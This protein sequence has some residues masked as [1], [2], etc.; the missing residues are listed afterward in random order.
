M[1][2]GEKVA[3]FIDTHMKKKNQKIFQVLQDTL[4]VSEVISSVAGGD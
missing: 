1:S 3:L 4:S 2:V